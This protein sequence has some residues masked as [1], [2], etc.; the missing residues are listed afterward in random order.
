MGAKRRTCDDVSLAETQCAQCGGFRIARRGRPLTLGATHARLGS[1]PEAAILSIL[2]LT[3]LAL[4][5][6]PGRDFVPY[7]WE[8]GR[9][10]IDSPNNYSI[11]DA[12]A[13]ASDIWLI[14]GHGPE[15]I[16]ADTYDPASAGTGIRV[17]APPIG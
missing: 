4:A 11:Y 15:S 14:Y 13:F 8:T 3:S 9:K 16:Y 17:T 10:D 6:K 5:A 2:S 12:F 7:A 1:P